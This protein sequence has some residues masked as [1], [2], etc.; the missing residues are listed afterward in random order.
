MTQKNVHV[1]SDAD[2]S[3]FILQG[4]VWPTRFL[5]CTAIKSA[6]HMPERSLNIAH[7]TES[8]ARQG[9]T[10]LWRG[11]LAVVQQGQRKKPS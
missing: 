9:E 4:I 2:Y 7:G 5:C 1:K 3:R 8:L 10:R 6:E 11:S